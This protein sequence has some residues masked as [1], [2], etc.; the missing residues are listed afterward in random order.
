MCEHTTEL[1][2][3]SVFIPPP[4]PWLFSTTSLILPR[5]HNRRPR[6]PSS[7]YHCIFY[8]CMAPWAFLYGGERRSRNHNIII[9]TRTLNQKR[10]SF[11]VGWPVH[12]RNILARADFDLIFIPVKCC[13]KHEQ[14]RLIFLNIHVVLVQ[15]NDRSTNIT[16]CTTL[17]RRAEVHHVH[18]TLRR[19]LTVCWRHQS[20]HL[21]LYFFNCQSALTPACEDRGSTVEF[22]DRRFRH[23]KSVT[24]RREHAREQARTSGDFINVMS[25]LM[26]AWMTCNHRNILEFPVN[27]QLWVNIT[28]CTVMMMMMM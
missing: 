3:R 14:L 22:L 11:G 24:E 9:I 19:E 6:A 18:I 21:S 20:K 28:Y 16:V 25:Y 10:P 12:R 27:W 15:Q 26:W 17:T 13:C 7:Y 1:P 4:A 5:V 2:M 8:F 23:M